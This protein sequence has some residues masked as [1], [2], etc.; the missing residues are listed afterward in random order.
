MIEGERPSD[1]AEPRA[2]AAQ[3][4]ASA[5]AAAVLAAEAALADAA[6]GARRREAIRSAR[7]ALKSVRALGAALRATIPT[8]DRDRLGALDAVLEFAGQ[9]NQLLGPLRD[10]DALGRTIQR[11]ADRF[12]DSETRRVTRTVLHATLVLA[13]GGR[14]DHEQFAETAIERARRALRSA[15]AALASATGGAHEFAGAARLLARTHRAM[16]EDLVAAL[17][18]SDLARLHECRKRAS[19]LA[20]ALAPA[21]AAEGAPREVRRL[22]SRARRLAAAIGEDRDLALLD[23][24]MRIARAR[25]EGSPLVAAIDDAIRLAR[26]EAAARMEDRARAFLRLG[27]RRIERALRAIG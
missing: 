13:Q 10:R 18:E 5:C 17:A 6:P 23:V 1:G 26:L 12:V 16:R 27:G 25:L 7:R 15:H 19:F 8:H 24:E 2:S 21:I 4:V 11:L 22:A 9:A 3:A 14:R 20:L